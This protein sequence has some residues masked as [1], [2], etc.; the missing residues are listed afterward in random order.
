MHP[1][2]NIAV[3][4]ARRAGEVIVRNLDRGGGIAAS[5][6]SRNDFVSE[7]DRAAEQVLIATIRKSYPDHGF[8]AEESGSHDGGDYTWIIDP[9]DG[10]TN[11]LHGFPQFA[12]SVACR[13]R[14][15]MEVGVV[16]DPLR[17]ELFTAARG[18]G[19][20]LDGRRLR[21]TQRLGLDGALIGTG[22]PYREN[23]RWL[24]PYLAMLEYV[25]DN[26]AGVRRPGAAALDLAYVAAGR[27]D[28]FWEVGLAPWDTAAGNLLITEAGGRIGTLA[29]GDYRDGGNLVAG[30]PRVY[31]ALIE[32]FA[33]FL[34]EELRK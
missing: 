29:G 31:T 6:K 12:V 2:V 5:E 32:A 15:R 33:P 10:T 22:F 28:G 20:Q 13:H 24:K 7:V 26:T 11:F 19:A 3:G 16:L 17:G 34:T 18:E 1:L 8:L 27:L 4:A 30:N 9:L 25:M 14:D 23:K 21:V